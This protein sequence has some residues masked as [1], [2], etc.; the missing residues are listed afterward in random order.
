M[1]C[2]QSLPTH[3]TCSTNAL[4]ESFPELSPLPPTPIELPPSLRRRAC[5]EQV[6][7]G[8]SLSNRSWIALWTTALWER[9]LW[10]VAPIE[11]RGP[12]VGLRY[13]GKPCHRRCIPAVADRPDP[14]SGTQNPRRWGEPEAH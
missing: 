1:R 11:V 10:E 9:G 8:G 13:P 6:A 12:T 5:D 7:S 3:P 4:H 14:L 2:P